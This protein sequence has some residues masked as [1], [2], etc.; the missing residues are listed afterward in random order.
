MRDGMFRHVRTIWTDRPRPTG[1]PQLAET[2][3]KRGVWI[4]LVSILV[5][6]FGGGGFFAYSVYSANQRAE[7]IVKAFYENEIES[8]EC[9]EP[10]AS[11]EETT[12][13]FQSHCL[14]NGVASSFTIAG[15]K[16]QVFGSPTYVD[17]LVERGGV[18]YREIWQYFNLPDLTSVWVEG[19]PN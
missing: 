17:V 7:S 4:A 8:G 13:E 9:L 5:L 14:A 6:Y 11:M 12:Q 18:V 16:S 19:G 3:I 1:R 2:K 10:K 15:S